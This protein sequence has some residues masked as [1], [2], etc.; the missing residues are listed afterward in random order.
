MFACLIIIIDLRRKKSGVAMLF[1][2]K[3]ISVM[4]KV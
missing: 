4:F 3:N 2:T 1:Y